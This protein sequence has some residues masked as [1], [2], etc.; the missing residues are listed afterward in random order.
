MGDIAAPDTLWFKFWNVIA[1]GG[2]TPFFQLPL[3]CS[4]AADQCLAKKYAARATVSAVTYIAFNYFI[5]AILTLWPESFAVDL[6][7]GATAASSGLTSIAGIITLDT[8]MMGGL[9]I[10][11]IV[12]YLHNRFY[13]KELP[14][15]LSNFSGSVFVTMISF[16]AMVPLAVLMCFVWPVIQEGMKACKAFSLNRETSVSLFISSCKNTDSNRLASLCLCTVCL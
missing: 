6:A 12:V 5:N 9:L 13:E 3:I 4:R 16:F 1:A 2:W 10:S 14:E 11:G 8:G 15:M 7:Q